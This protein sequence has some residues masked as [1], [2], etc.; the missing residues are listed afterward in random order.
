MKKKYISLS[1]LV[2]VLFVGGLLVGI[3]VNSKS[4]TKE[5]NSITQQE[6][7]SMPEEAKN[8]SHIV[9]LETSKGE[10]Q[11]ETY[12][13]DAPL[14]SANFTKLAK[15]GFYDNLVFHRVIKGFMIQGGDP[16]GNGTGGP[17]YS[18]AD[19]LNSETESY[20]A[21]YKKGVVAMANAG[22]N[23][24][25]SQFFIMLEDNDQ[26]PHAYTIFGKVLKGQDVV[27]AIG[28]T[29][30]NPANDRPLESVI[31]KKITVSDVTK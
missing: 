10:I 2:G 4:N 6:K 23:T 16:E 28:S 19:E 12:D 31:I 22:P 18:F 8:G 9:T 13:A 21:G 3:V 26:L 15:E 30:T 11:F 5:I 29:A 1:I 14:A 17:G 25:G 7:K 27:S 20:K 24:N